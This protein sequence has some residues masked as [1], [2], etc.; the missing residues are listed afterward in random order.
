MR[1]ARA[2][3][4]DDTASR[5]YLHAGELHVATAPAIV[6]TVLGSC[7]SV[8]LWDP[9]RAL[10]GLSHFVLP[11]GTATD[12]GPKFGDDAIDALTAG[13]L[14]LGC[15]N[16]VAK[17]FGGAAVLPFN[18]ARPTVGELNA[19]LALRRLREL[20]IPVVSSHLGGS[21]GV[22]IRLHSR[23]GDVMLRRIPSTMR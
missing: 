23:S 15:R 8:C 21:N 22:S 2:A 3:Q 18:P 4:P 12:R 17:V 7:V 16:L 14:A 10:G 1:R 11:T 6:S 5:V 19:R 13:M 9:R 20:G